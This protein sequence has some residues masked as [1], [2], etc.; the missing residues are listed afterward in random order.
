LAI[1]LNACSNTFLKPE[2]EIQQCLKG[3]SEQPANVCY[4]PLTVLPGGAYILKRCRAC[5]AELVADRSHTADLQKLVSAA[6][7]IKMITENSFGDDGTPTKD[8]PCLTEW[9]DVHH[10]LN[11]I[12]TTC[13]KKFLQQRSEEITKIDTL[14]C[15]VRAVVWRRY[16][17]HFGKVLSDALT[18]FLKNM[19]VNLVLP[20]DI[21]P[22]EIEVKRKHQVDALIRSAIIAFNVVKD[23]LALT[24][25]DIGYAAISP[26]NMIN[27]KAKHIA[28][29]T[30]WLSTVMIVGIRPALRLR[31]CGAVPGRL[32]CRSVRWTSSAVGCQPR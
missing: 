4:K 8:M 1:L 25:R 6:E 17:S 3:L 9:V 31:H 5:L 13:S 23:F 24:P 11:R 18:V 29:L 30:G 2:A 14:L 12:E 28:D 27:I 10:K 22:V 7:K 32:R 16:M 19:K 15:Q 21:A 20:T 26:N